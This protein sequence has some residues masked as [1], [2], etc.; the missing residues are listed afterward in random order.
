MRKIFTILGICIF[1]CACGPE[2]AMNDNEVQ[3]IKQQDDVEVQGVEKTDP[4]EVDEESNTE[5]ES[6]IIVS[7]ADDYPFGHGLTDGVIVVSSYAVN[8]SNPSV[9]YDI[10]DLDVA[11]NYDGLEISECQMIFQGREGYPNPQ[12]YT[13]SMVYRLTVTDPASGIT[14]YWS[15][16]TGSTIPAGYYPDS[17]VQIRCKIQGVNE[18]SYIQVTLIHLEYIRWE[19]QSVVEFRQYPDITAQEPYKK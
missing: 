2:V 14:Q 12:T 18:L 13:S 1:V 9:A 16:L 3:A 8:V 6:G 7:L 10:I 11:I 17:T 4:Q 5:L 19:Y 15:Q